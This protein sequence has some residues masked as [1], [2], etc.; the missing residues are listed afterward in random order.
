M[1]AQYR[2]AV[3]SPDDAAQYWVATSMLYH[4]AKTAGPD[5]TKPTAETKQ[6]LEE[7]RPFLERLAADENHIVRI[8]AAEALGRYGTEADVAKAEGILLETMSD[9][10]AVA[11][12][13]TFLAFI[14]LDTFA[15][16][17]TDPEFKDRVKAAAESI[18]SP[19]GRTSQTFDRIVQS[20]LGR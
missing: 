9:T 2:G 1:A 6:F 20:V 8:P 19:A 14:S 4:L 13:R 12:Y 17:I 3:N 15:S 11:F 5:G 10:S 16:R 18:T 7:L